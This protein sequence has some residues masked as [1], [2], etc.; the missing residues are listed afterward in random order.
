[1]NIMGRANIK[2]K[3]PQIKRLTNLKAVQGKILIWSEQG[4]GD[5]IQF[6]DTFVI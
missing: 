1:M 2:Y 4:M 5:T 6:Q 3:C